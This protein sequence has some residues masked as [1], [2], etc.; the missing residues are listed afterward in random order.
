MTDLIMPRR[1]FLTGLMGLVA[2][3]AVVKAASIMPV[4]VTQPKWYLAEGEF[5]TF[6]TRVWVPPNS[7][8]NLQ[9]IRDLLMPGLNKM[10]D[11]MYTEHPGQWKS[12]FISDGQ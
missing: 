9:Q 7:G 8:I 4:K 10:V 12:I 2:A 6:P 3:P 5:H 11:D 1:K